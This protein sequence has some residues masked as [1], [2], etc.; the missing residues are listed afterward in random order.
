MR[1]PGYRDLLSEIC[2][3]LQLLLVLPATNAE[4]ERVFSTQKRIKT[5]LRSSMGQA[6]L[7]HLMLMNIHEEE[8]KSLSLG[9]VANEFGSKNDRRRNDF[10]VNKF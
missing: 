10:G 6:R 8:A 4:S 7:N 3:V 9:V 2:I 1:K 5:Y